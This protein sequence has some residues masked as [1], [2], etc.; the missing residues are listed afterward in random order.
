MDGVVNI[1]ERRNLEAMRINLGIGE[2]EAE[3]IEKSVAPATYIEYMTKVEV[4]F[5][6]GEI[7]V[8]ERKYLEGLRERLGLDKDTAD[9]IEESVTSM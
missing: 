9:A 2:E 6:D 8:G 1:Q 4:F 3:S 7:S 5:V